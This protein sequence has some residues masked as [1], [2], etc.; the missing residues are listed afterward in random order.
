MIIALA[1]DYDIRKSYYLMD[2]DE[3]MSRDEIITEIQEIL[4]KYIKTEKGK[5]F[6]RKNSEKITLHDFFDEWLNIPND[7]FDKSRI[8]IQ[9][10]FDCLEN[11]IEYP[12][13]YSLYETKP[14]NAVFGIYDEDYSLTNYDMKKLMDSVNW[15]KDYAFRALH[16]DGRL[17]GFGFVSL[18]LVDASD[19]NKFNMQEFLMEV[20][21]L[22]YKEAVEDGAVYE[23][24]DTK[25][26]MIHLDW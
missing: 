2:I 25:F 17:V 11:V 9:D 8:H 7:I 20:G 16:C 14:I 21:D 5:I 24:Q 22:A 13:F 12:A 15:N 10:I 6:L 1:L 4:E 3:G 19:K 23:R 18:D 26:K